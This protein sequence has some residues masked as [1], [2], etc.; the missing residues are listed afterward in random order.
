MEGF[1]LTQVI[2]AV[3]GVLGTIVT[4]FLIPLLRQKLTE[5]QMNKLAAFAKIGVYAAEQLY[6]PDEWESKKKYVQR[7]LEEKGY[8]VNLEEVNAAIESSVK[9]LRIAM[10]SK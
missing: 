1:D 10:E 4:S 2:I 9:E 3:I 5:A 7:F 8:D 6:Y